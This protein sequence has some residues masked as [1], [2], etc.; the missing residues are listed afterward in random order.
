MAAALL[1]QQRQGGLN[2]PKRTKVVCVK[3]RADIRLARFLNRP[4][5]RVA[6]IV[7][8]NVQPAKVRVGLLNRL[9]HLISIRH[10]ERQW[11]YGVAEALC[12]IGNIRHFA[13]GRCN[14]VAALKRGFGPN[15][16]EAA[17]R[18]GDKPNFAHSVLLR[19]RDNGVLSRTLRRSIPAYL[20][21]V[22]INM[23]TV[24]I[25]KNISQKRPTYH[26]GD[27]RTALIQAA[28][29]I[30]AE[31]GIEAFSLRAAAKRAGVSPGAPAH[32]FGSA[33]GLLTEGARLAFER[34]GRAVEEVGHSD[35][36][37]ADVRALSLAFI[38]FV[39]DHPGHFRLMFRS[40]LVNRDDPR[41]PE[42]SMKP[43]KRIDRAIAAYHG[44]SDVDLN[45]FEDAADIFCGMA[46]LYGMATLVLEEK[47]AH[48]FDNAT[49]QD[50]AQNELPRVLERLYPSKEER[51][52]R[53]QGA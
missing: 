41:Y 31:G 25:N 3:L 30:I 15:A 50:F 48:F 35:D 49:S 38:S 36:A 46:T 9:L 21:T 45:R 40:D 24:K 22:K 34:R 53:R 13:G 28:D 10:V 26:H 16:S 33:K 18:A 39:L 5:Q 11:E 52:D 2:D 37:A 23:N 17:R 29:D 4:D 14:F 44:K 43:G 47:A 20:N 12:E 19:V 8:D 27:L 42:M 1:P 51:K 6:G 7:D 32:H